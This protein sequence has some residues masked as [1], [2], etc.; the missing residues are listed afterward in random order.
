MH[1][2]LLP[3]DGHIAAPTGSRAAAL[4]ALG[5][6]AACKPTVAALQRISWHAVRLLGPK[7]LPGRVVSWT[8]P[9]AEG[10]WVELSGRLRTEIG[11]HDDA[12]F[13]LRRPPDRA[14]FS[15]LRLERGETRA[16]VKFRRAGSGQLEAE[17]RALEALD[18]S[19]I[20]F[21]APSV[22]AAGE[23][24]GWDYLALT[25]LPLRIHRMPTDPPLAEISRQIG[26]ALSDGLEH[27]DGIDSGWVP[28]HG[29]L[30]PWN[31]REVPGLGLALFDWEDWGW[32][33]PGS[34]LVWYDVACVASGIPV[35][36]SPIDHPRP[37]LEFW[38]NRLTPYRE[39]GEKSLQADA[40]DH[41]AQWI[42]GKVRSAR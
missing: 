8:M 26:L 2:K 7:L 23:V 32:A 16:F 17:R 37:A 10:E 25:A 12:A 19:I 28:M 21:S 18:R 22:L 1:L 33:P 41:L 5:M 42:A 20:S 11:T 13:H 27:P 14:G 35:R 24:G 38:L 34:D 3:P 6:Y 4:A 31:L 39:S 9:I 36:H 40:A 30:T 29:D 15:M